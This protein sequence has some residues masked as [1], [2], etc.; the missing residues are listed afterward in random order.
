MVLTKYYWCFCIGTC[1]GGL[2][3]AMVKALPHGH[4]GRHALFHH[5]S[6]VRCLE[7]A[8]AAQWLSCHSLFHP[9]SASQ[10]IGRGKGHGLPKGLGSL[11]LPISLVLPISWSAGSRDV[12]CPRASKPLGFP[13]PCSLLIHREGTAIWGRWAPGPPQHCQDIVVGVQPFWLHPSV[14]ITAGSL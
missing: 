11:G 5:L 14:D 8:W 1:L 4:M 12:C 6:A 13:C 7:Q 2:M 3:L 10:L 9:L